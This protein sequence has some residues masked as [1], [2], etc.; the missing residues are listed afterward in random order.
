VKFDVKGFEASV[1]KRMEC[2]LREHR[3]RKVIVE[4]NVNPAKALTGEQDHNSFMAQF[5]YVPTVNS[6][7]CHHFD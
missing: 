4:E 7:G 2:L 1:L 3:C 6:A 5:G